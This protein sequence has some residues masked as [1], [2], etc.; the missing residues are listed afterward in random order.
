MT[1]D[2]SLKKFAI[3]YLIRKMIDIQ[4][5]FQAAEI[6]RSSF[7][8]FCDHR[9]KF[10]KTVTCYK[11]SLSTVTYYFAKTENNESL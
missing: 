2:L 11:C 3:L 6:L 7:A 4:P 5:L 10:S 8:K 1:Y 9:K